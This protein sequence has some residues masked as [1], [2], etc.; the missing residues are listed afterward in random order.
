MDVP[1]MLFFFN[2]PQVLKE[3]FKWIQR[4]KP[5]QLFLVQ[6]GPRCGN[7]T[8]IE[9]VM[10]CREIVENIDWDCEIR[11]NY[12]E[13]NMGCDAREFSGIDW[14]FQFVDRLI[15]LEDDCVPAISFYD[16]CGELLQRYKDNERVNAIS[17]FV[18]CR[19][20]GETMYDYVFSH[21]C[22]GW[23]WATWKR[24]WDEALQVYNMEIDEYEKTLHK[25]KNTIE[26]YAI[27]NK[28]YV[29]KA[30]NIRR[31]EEKAGKIISWENIWGL[32]M[33]LHNQMSISPKVNMIRYIG[34]SADATHAHDK[35]ELMPH[36]I[37]EMV[38]QPAIELQGTIKHPPYI[39]RDMQYEKK[40]YDQYFGRSSILMHIEVLLLK[41][42]YR[43]FDI[44]FGR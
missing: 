44:I 31:K 33:M 14:C 42:R 32:S 13:E 30:I 22:A 41:I 28:G 2:R 1:V 7:M 16:F 10:K 25:Y 3:S 43:R 38:E 21:T 36:V 29:E 5:R 39:V 27:H 24:A 19:E 35:I 17:G 6:D 4:V 34:I 18:R 37:R 40:D 23:G 26:N 12:S 11:K 9:K 20:T 8:D 15:I